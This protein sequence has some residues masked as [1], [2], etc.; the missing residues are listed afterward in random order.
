MKFA[1]LGSGS[2]GNATLVRDGESCLLIDCG[3][4]LKEVERRLARLQFC[5]DDISAILVTHEHGDHAR[6]VAA[7]SRKY[8]TPVYMTAG[9]RRALDANIDQLELI[10]S[11]HRAFHCASFE[12]T[13]VAVPHDAREPVQFVLRN[14][15]H[16]LGLLTDLGSITQ[17]VVECFQHCDGLLLEANHDTEMLANGPYP[18]SLKRRVGGDW[19]H[20]NN[21]QAR[22]LLDNICLDK[23]QQLV[24]GHISEKNNSL[25]LVKQAVDNIAVKLPSVNYACQNQGFDWIQLN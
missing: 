2:K 14:Q 23:I 1:S 20:L 13:P 3:F 6:G 25:P 22:W 11:S 19:G 21:L 24:L 10:D 17:H 5:P 8:K 12:V 18:P 7:F 9:T 15:R 4:S 16:T